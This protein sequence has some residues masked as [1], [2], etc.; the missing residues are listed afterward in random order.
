MYAE[1]SDEVREGWLYLGD[2]KFRSD[3][4]E[5]LQAEI[6][7]I[8]GQLREMHKESLFRD[9]LKSQIT[10]YEGELETFGAAFD[11]VEAETGKAKGKGANAPPKTNPV[12]ELVKKKNELVQKLSGLLRGLEAE[13]VSPHEEG[14]ENV[15]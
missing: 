12:L 2:G 11:F 15:K 7:T 8:D 5:R 10:L 14:N 1:A 6:D 9:W 4:P 13:S 3:E